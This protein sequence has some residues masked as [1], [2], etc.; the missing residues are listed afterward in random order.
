MIF[1]ASN[2]LNRNRSHTE[3]LD[4]MEDI[5]P[6]SSSS[7]Y[8]DNRQNQIE[9]NFQGLFPT[10]SGSSTVISD[11]SS[12]N[13]RKPRFGFLRKRPFKSSSSLNGSNGSTPSASASR[14]IH[15]NNNVH[16]SIQTQTNYVTKSENSTK[17]TLTSLPFHILQQIS[18]LVS[19]N[20]KQDLL[21][22]GKSCKTL[23]YYANLVLYKNLLLVDGNKYYLNSISQ[24]VMNQNAPTI[25]KLDKLNSMISSLSSN[26][27]LVGFID[28]V[29]ILVNTA[30]YDN[31]ST[32][33]NSSHFYLNSFLPSTRNQATSNINPIF[34]LYNF[35][36]EY[37]YNNDKIPLK[38]L[39]NIKILDIEE[40]TQNQSFLSYNQVYLDSRQLRDS[41][42]SLTPMNSNESERSVISNGS[43]NTNSRSRRLFG[44]T[45]NT[46]T[47]LLYENDEDEFF[48]YDHNNYYKFVNNTVQQEDELNSIV[49]DGTLPK[50]TAC[51]SSVIELE[52]YQL[53]NVNEINDLPI[54]ST[55]EIS[56]YCPST[57]RRNG[58]DLKDNQA[59]FEPFDNRSILFQNLTS[60]EF[61]STSVFESFFHSLLISKNKNNFRFLNLEK[62]S[63]T[64][65]NKELKNKK[66]IKNFIE[67]INFNNLKSFELKF[68][69]DQLLL[70]NEQNLREA[71]EYNANLIDLL[72][73]L[74][75]NSLQLTS[76]SVTQ[77][78]SSNPLSSSNMT[79]IN[80]INN[81]NNND[82]NISS[83]N[84]ILL[85]M[86]CNSV[87][88]LKNLKF[89]NIQLNNFP[90]LPFTR[91]NFNRESAEEMSSI[92]NMNNDNFMD[93]QLLMQRQ[94]NEYGISNN[95]IENKF[96]DF[97]RFNNNFNSLEVLVIP[98]YF[99]NWKPFLKINDNGEL[100]KSINLNILN[101]LYDCK[102]D[103]CCNLRK[104]FSLVT[105]TGEEFSWPNNITNT[106]NS[107]TAENCKMVYNFL[108]LQLRRRLPLDD[109]MMNGLD[110]LNLPFV[111]S[112]RN[113]N[114]SPFNNEDIKLFL[115]LIL[116][117]L[118][119]DLKF[120]IKNNERLKVLL[121]GGF[122][123]KIT[124]LEDI[125]ENINN[126]IDHS[127][128]EQT[129]H[130]SISDDILEQMSSKATDNSI[131]YKIECVYEDYEFYLSI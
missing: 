97:K 113:F 107:F 35:L 36:I 51:D 6:T 126:D 38:G 73:H 8:S 34:K 104:K 101:Y 76:L 121:I 49:Y 105:S 31:S 48:N 27:N 46:I 84:I 111:D 87:Q 108:I 45:K 91:N 106:N 50:D 54:H 103:S 89:L 23:N 82:D 127:L 57:V 92:M 80:N 86:I 40:L 18:T 9:N 93:P 83:N 41:P 65:I 116:H 67:F 24:Q 85:N 12:G 55:R 15:K 131:G 42:L 78:C 14:S 20:S 44:G 13:M 21:K 53:N 4:S 3:Q 61:K 102:C 112:L 130:I 128:S 33:N 52:S 56:L 81:N 39:K 11:S 10:N 60:L 77:F 2:N 19:N 98:D 99:Y 110:I 114:C 75:S 100:N 7:S 79:N 69:N 95:F 37:K 74:I 96:N 28:S 63:I 115:K 118:T 26:P 22:L 47:R 62:L 17:N 59:I 70:N 16:K 43:N 32:D 125:N 109:V 64:L 124:K 90:F 25:L 71:F 129:S 1:R 58:S 5:R 123:F 68:S 122:V 29:S 119:N 88:F 94:L 30:N 117:N 72:D 66:L 120:F